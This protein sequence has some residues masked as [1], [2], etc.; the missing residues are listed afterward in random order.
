[1]VDTGVMPDQQKHPNQSETPGGP[2]PKAGTPWI[3]LVAVG[4]IFLGTAVLIRPLYSA[5]ESQSETGA[6]Y[7]AGALAGTPALLGQMEGRNYI[8][9]V[10]SGEDEPRYTV[11]T[12]SGEPIIEDLYAD[13]VYTYFPNLDIES[14]QFGPDDQKSSEWSP[15]MMV[16][17]N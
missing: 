2:I 10:Y 14:M 15:L 6:S 1:M 12:L 5:A 4:A 7:G 16:D 17:H 3:V 13:E 8:V 9:R 11:C